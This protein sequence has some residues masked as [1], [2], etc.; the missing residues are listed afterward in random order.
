MNILSH[1]STSQYCHAECW[2][3]PVSSCTWSS[4][5]QRGEHSWGWWP[6]RRRGRSRPPSSSET[7][8]RCRSRRRCQR[9]SGQCS[10]V[11]N[12]SSFPSSLTNI[13]IWKDLSLWQA[14]LYLLQHVNRI[15]SWLNDYW[16][17]HIQEIWWRSMIMPVP[18]GSRSCGRP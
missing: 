9:W 18:F 13:Q 17:L 8:R 5:S 15:R 3:S 2:C 7:R 12:I 6:C 11:S 10:R 1:Q 14:G 16:N 4:R